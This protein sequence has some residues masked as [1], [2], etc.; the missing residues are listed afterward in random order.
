M[1]SKYLRKSMNRYTVKTLYLF[2]VCYAGLLLSPLYSQEARPA[3]L[4]GRWT[5]TDLPESDLYGNTYNEVW[6]LALN[7]REYA[8]I[9]SSEGTHFIDV[10]RPQDA[11]EVAFVA[12]ASAGERVIH[13]DYH[14]YGCYLYA[15]S[16]EGNGSLQIIDVSGLPDSVEVVYDEDTFFGR[17]HNIFIDTSTAILYACYARGGEA[18][19]TPL[20]LLDLSDPVNPR[21][22]ATYKDFGSGTVSHVH[23][24]YVED[25]IAFLNLGFDGMAVVDFSDPLQPVNLSTLTDYPFSGYN[26]SGWP[27]TDGQYYYL[28]DESHGYPIKILDIS[29]LRELRVIGDFD[30]ASINELSIAHNQLVAC[31]YLYVSYY[32]DGLQVYDISDPKQPRRVSYYSTS[33]RDHRKSYEGAWGVYPF[34]PSGN[35]LVS[36]MQEGLFILSSPDEACPSN[37]EMSLTCALVSPVSTPPAS[38]THLSVYPVPARDQLIVSLNM[39]GKSQEKVN[40]RLVDIHGRSLQR[41]DRETLGDKWQLPLMPDI[42]PGVYILQLRIGPDYYHKQILIHR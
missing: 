35:I 18:T 19:T 1:F 5:G 33:S 16:D 8:V 17:S 4:L 13:R 41:W 34:L 9:G 30:A 37:A 39:A 31:D 42:P 14:H 6:G 38:T 21:E 2:F 27:T 26:H 36:D 32:Y 10:T 20:K 40:A 12:G 3:S 11:Q 23:D 22:L 24:C 7:G 29:D 28:G 25:G 15:V